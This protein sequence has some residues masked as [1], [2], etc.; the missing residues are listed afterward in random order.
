[1]LQR[2][3][4]ATL[5]ALMFA[6][7][8]GGVPIMAQVPYANQTVEATASEPEKVADTKKTE[9]KKQEKVATPN[10]VPS[11]PF[12][13]G[14]TQEG[15]DWYYL[16]HGQKLKNTFLVK[17][18]NLYH[19]DKEGKRTTG[20]LQDEGGKTYFFDQE[21]RSKEGWITDKDISYYLLNGKCVTGWLQIPDTTD[22]YF[23][24]ATG[25]MMSD[26]VTPDGYYVD[27]TGKY[28]DEFGQK[29]AGDGFSWNK[30][31]SAGTGQISGLE[32][33]GMPAEFFMLSI[34]GETSGMSNANAPISGDSGRAYGAC[35]FDYR[36][37][38]VDFMRFAYKK[39]P[40]LWP[41]F[42]KYL[43]YENGDE[44]LRN[45][46]NI[47]KAFLSAMDVDYETCMTDQLEFVRIRYW[48]SFQKQMNNA[49]F[50]LNARPI[51]VQAAFL[52]VNVNCGAQADKFIAAMSPE[53]SDEAMIRK[54]YEVR[55]TTL[56][57]QKVGSKKKGTSAR[58]R[59]AEPQIALDLLYGYV[60]IDSTISYGG[61]VE[62]NGN[63]F[64]TQ[65]TTVPA[66]TRV[67]YEKEETATPSEATP[68]FVQ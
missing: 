26:Y 22:W 58:Y 47:G 41:G 45:N 49:G 16:D 17:E 12:D 55:N 39:H 4:T 37:D 33:A 56:A 1:M 5:S 46:T 27:E 35:Q 19:F 60:T 32:I 14:F 40:D 61:G 18:G 52:S 67:L 68:S 31:R 57:A 29:Q 10:K 30:D 9:M 62:W 34:A 50:D 28:V 63:P 7:A 23:F 44:R 43:Q 64:T 38:L 2:K 36:Y 24:D 21:D 66:A 48:D 15:D 51:A 3:R 65:I 13:T 42:E 54:I 6:L 53:M 8:L 20:W 59:H 25:K 11:K